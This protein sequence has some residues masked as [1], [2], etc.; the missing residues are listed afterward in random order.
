MGGRRLAGNCPTFLFD[1]HTDLLSSNGWNLLSVNCT[2]GAT[3]NVSGAGKRIK[4][5]RSPFAE[6]VVE[7]DRHA[8][9]VNQGRHFYVANGAALEV[10]GLILTGGYETVRFFFLN[11]TRL[12]LLIKDMYWCCCFCLRSSSLP[13]TSCSSLLLSLSLLFNLPLDL[14]FAAW[15]GGICYRHWFFRHL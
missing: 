13:L 11:A 8:T 1:N 14:L 4:I 2:L 15:R 7:V 3:F 12:V 6:G 5:K 9:S 10:D